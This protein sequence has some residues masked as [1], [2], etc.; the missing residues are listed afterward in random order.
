MMHSLISHT[1]KRV[2]WILMR[3]I[4]RKIGDVLGEDQLGFR[5][6]K[7]TRNAVGVK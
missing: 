3:R 1:A 6:G 7:G 2:A 5:R 4:E